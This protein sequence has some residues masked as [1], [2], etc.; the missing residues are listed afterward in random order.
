MHASHED[1]EVG[2]S[3]SRRRSGGGAAR[4]GRSSARS[5]RTASH[6]KDG[7]TAGIIWRILGA[8]KDLLL[9]VLSLLFNLVRLLVT[10][11][12]GRVILLVAI[13]ALAVF[14][15]ST[16][17]TQC[18]Q[19]DQGDSSPAEQSDTRYAR[20]SPS[21]SD[22]ASLQIGSDGVATFTLNVATPD[23]T[24]TLSDEQTQKINDAL[25]PF[26]SNDRTVG[27]MQGNCSTTRRSST[28]C[29]WRCARCCRISAQVPTAC[30][31]WLGGG[32]RMT[33]KRRAALWEGI[34]RGPLEGGLRW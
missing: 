26:T 29:A 19:D 33:A 9:A 23:V 27:F 1:G 4:N 30:G 32:C 7:R 5:E 21:T 11:L 18:S 34:R 15:I 2:R 8:V 13:I 10:T 31:S 14:L 20:Y 3:R 17:V 25:E 6:A 28:R 24:P 12:P 16:N 22:V